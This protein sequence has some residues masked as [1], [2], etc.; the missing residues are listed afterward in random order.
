MKTLSQSQ[1]YSVK[2]IADTFATPVPRAYHHAPSGWPFTW[3]W[4]IQEEVQEEIIAINNHLSKAESVGS[5]FDDKKLLCKSRQINL[6]PDQLI[7]DH[8]QNLPEKE[9]SATYLKSKFLPENQL[10]TEN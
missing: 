4:G 5:A 10:Q 1:K 2:E 6:V 9:H 3:S 8:V 7:C